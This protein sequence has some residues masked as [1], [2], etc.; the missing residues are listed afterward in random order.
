MTMVLVVSLFSWQLGQVKKQQEQEAR[1]SEDFN[2]LER[3]FD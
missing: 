3:T 1:R 2:L